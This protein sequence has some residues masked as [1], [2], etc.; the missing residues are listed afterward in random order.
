MAGHPTFLLKSWASVTISNLLGGCYNTILAVTMYTLKTDLGQT[1]IHKIICKLQW[2]RRL[3]HKQHN[4]IGNVQ[5]A[6]IVLLMH[7]IMNFATVP[8]SQAQGLTSTESSQ[9]FTHFHLPL[10]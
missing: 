2:K 1:V 3:V 7:I 4:I 8:L 10:P 6:T 9:T 5:S